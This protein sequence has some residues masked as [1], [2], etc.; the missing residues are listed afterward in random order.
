MLNLVVNHHRGKCCV[1]YKGFDE[2]L[3]E[4]SYLS[5]DI[6][7]ID[8]KLQ[9]L[10]PQYIE[11]ISFVQHKIFLKS[12]EKVKTLKG[13]FN[14]LKDI[15]N[16]NIIP[17]NHV[18]VL[19][20]ATI[21]DTAGTALALLK[22]G[23]KWTY[24]PTTL[25]AQTDSCIGSKTSINGNESK[26]MYGLFFSPN[27][28]YIVSDFLKSLPDIEILS[29]IGDALH[30]LLLDIGITYQ[31]A[32]KTLQKISNI[33]LRKF[34]DEPRNVYLLSSTVHKIKKKYI[35]E[36]EFDQSKRKVLNLGHSFGHAVEAFFNYEVPHGVGV[37]IGLIMAIDISKK[38]FER[39][40]DLIFIDS[41][42]ALKNEMH[43]L[44]NQ[45]Y[46]TSIKII[47]LTISND[48]ERFLKYL[49]KDKKNTQKNNYNLVLF[50]NNIVSIECVKK[51]DMIKYIKGIISS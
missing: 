13:V 4:I 42:N 20:G 2:S 17:I 6:A 45:N 29:G 46:S 23:I 44:L 39:K 50:K 22:R 18:F 31:Y 36:D 7:I 10:Y 33:G 15:E 37:I 41:L 43:N 21:Q 16:L 30:Y 28:V 49:S 51:Q 24:M 26:N 47:F 40:N 3:L 8:S 5:P 34:V 12:G 48:Y 11:K 14:L 25:L 38:H 35:E 27:N 19:G 32:L 1:F 9:K